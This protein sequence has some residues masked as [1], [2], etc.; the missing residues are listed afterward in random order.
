MPEI[1]PIKLIRKTQI[2][3]HH[4]WIE[5]EEVLPN[6]TQPR[7]FVTERCEEHSRLAVVVELIMDA[8]LGENGTL[9]QRERGAEL[10]LQTVLKDEPRKDVVAFRESQELARAR[11]DVWFVHAAWV[12]EARRH[13]DTEVDEGREGR[14]VGKVALTAEAFTA[15]RIRIR[16]GVEVVF[17][18]GIGWTLSFEDLKAGFAVGSELELV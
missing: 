6:G 16:R 15:A 2:C 1:G 18:P 12:H 4:I 7:I 3:I 10:S 13:R 14:T 17:K 11:V 9:V 5:R 8:T